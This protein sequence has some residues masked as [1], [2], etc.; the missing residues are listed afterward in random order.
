MCMSARLYFLFFALLVTGI[1]R[2]GQDSIHH[3]QA[4]GFGAL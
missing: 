3:F 4:F 2:D 1:R